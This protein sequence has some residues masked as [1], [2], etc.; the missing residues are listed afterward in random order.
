VGAPGLLWWAGS[1][2]TRY[3]VDPASGMVGVYLTQVLPFPYL[4]LMNGVM[5]L[6]IQ[7]LE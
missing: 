7:A 3:W 4:D 6:S 5:R 2:N 1:T